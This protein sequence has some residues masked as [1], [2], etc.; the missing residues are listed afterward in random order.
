MAL[1]LD[2]LTPSKL[3]EI[4]DELLGLQESVPTLFC[5]LNT[6]QRRIISNSYTPQSSGTI[7]HVSFNTPANG[8]GKTHLMVMDMVGWMKGSEFLNRDAW[9]KVALEYY[10]SLKI[11]R[12][13]GL[14]TTRLVCDSVDMM[15][16]GSVYMLIKELIPDAVFGNMDNQKCYKQITIPHPSIPN[17]V[18]V[19][20]V[21]TFNQ[22]VRK[23]SGAN[24]LR[25]WVNEPMPQEIWG[26]TVARTRSKKGQVR[27]T[28]AVF[29]TVLNQA[30]YVS[31]LLENPRCVHT[32]GACWENCAGEEVTDEMAMEVLKHCNVQLEKNP[33]GPGYITY[34]V[35]SKESIEDIIAS[36]AAS[37][38]ELEARKFGKFMHLEG[39]VFK[40]LNSDVHL[41]KASYCE[42]IPK[43]LPVFQVVD[44]H[45]RH[46]D[47]SA[48]F[49]LT[50]NER[51]IAI[52]EYPSFQT[53]GVFFEQIKGI[54]PTIEQT[55]DSWRHIEAELGISGQ[56]AARIGDPN[57]FLD[58]HASDNNTLLY[59]YG[60][61]GFHFDVDVNDSVDIGHRFMQK[62]IAYNPLIRETNPNDPLAIPMLLISEECQ[63]IWRS[64]S[65]FSYKEKRDATAAPSEQFEEKF[66]CP[67]A[68]VRYM[69]MWLQGKT[70]RELAMDR[71][72]VG[73]YERIR[74]GR[75]PGG[76]SSRTSLASK[77]RSGQRGT[78]WRMA[79]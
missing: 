10:D 20:D 22:E 58:P 42:N 75:T 1:H 21:K 39:R 33:D 23:H 56:I 9:P 49:L 59:H 4:R 30:P 2:A 34:G 65:R 41:K 5:G 68:C 69:V 7:P 37:P 62:Y 6:C 26:E 24:C 63:N 54:R 67:V 13:R 50:P 40:T 64:L 3:H 11:L 18:N 38:E 16:N 66:G 73:D 47:F 48:W 28:V 12:N 27:G 31:D 43:N 70:F 15:A 72:R 17:V 36:W 52:A 45:G 55:C 53:H 51:L 19:I 78:A 76:M 8:V 29:A 44:P 61:H 32:T 79:S 60:L 14:L 77:V 35:L 74:S 46:P 25:I 57:R 71:N